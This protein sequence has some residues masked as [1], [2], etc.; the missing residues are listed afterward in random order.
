MGRLSGFGKQ[1]R[2]SPRNGGA[3]RGG[4]G[5]FRSHGFGHDVAKVHGCVEAHAVLLAVL[6]FD[7]AA[8]IAR[9]IEAR[10]GAAVVGENMRGGVDGQAARGEVER[11]LDAAHSHAVMRVDVGELLALELVFLACESMGVVRVEGLL[12]V[13]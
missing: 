5:D 1:S 12:Q 6:L 2:G 4:L 11:G 9:G 8:H 10:D 7:G 3:E 13:G